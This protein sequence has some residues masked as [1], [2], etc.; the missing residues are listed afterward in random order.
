MAGAAG[1]RG[2]EGEAEGGEG[3]AQGWRWAWRCCLGVGVE[4]VR[5]GC[6]GGVGAAWSNSVHGARVRSGNGKW[7][8]VAKGEGK[9]RKVRGHVLEW[10]KGSRADRNVSPNVCHV[11]MNMWTSVYVYEEVY[12]C[13]CACKSLWT[14]V[15]VRACT[16][17]Y[18]CVRARA[19]TRVY[20]RVGCCWGYQGCW[21]TRCG[22]RRV[23]MASF[24]LER[25]PRI[26]DLSADT[27]PTLLHVHYCTQTLPAAWQAAGSHQGA[28][29]WFGLTSDIR[30]NSLLLLLLLLL[31]RPGLTATNL[32]HAALLLVELR[33]AAPEALDTLEPLPGSGWALGV[34][35]G[36]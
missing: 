8:R 35:G 31:L 2:L 20:I 36:G 18:A 27:T 19:H 9:W 11:Y 29:L 34:E 28:F 32:L 25:L 23:P 10:C 16:H 15:H 7:R 14:R 1:E 21:L 12:A 5:R 17:V 4:G 33:A 24:V 26:K 30:S 3:A 22:L 6:V 13:V